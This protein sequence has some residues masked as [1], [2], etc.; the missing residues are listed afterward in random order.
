LIMAKIPGAGHLRATLTTT[1]E[2]L[3]DEPQSSELMVN[4]MRLSLAWILNA[5][6]G[7]IVKLLNI[8]DQD[9]KRDLLNALTRNR[10]IYSRDVSFSRRQVEETMK[11]MRAAGVLADASF[12][13]NTLIDSKLAGVRP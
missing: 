9:E 2:Q 6:A 10:D 4:M 11:F 8:K 12:D 7:E 13:L 5:N 1:A 3:S